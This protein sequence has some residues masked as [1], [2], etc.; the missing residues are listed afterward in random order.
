[1]LTGTA[2]AERCMA[3]HDEF[4][5]SREFQL[6]WVASGRSNVQYYQG[7]KFTSHEH[8][9][10]KGS[11]PRIGRVP[12]NIYHSFMKSISP[13]LYMVRPR[14][15]AQ[16]KD[17]RYH[18]GS[19]Q[20]EAYLNWNLEVTGWDKQIQYAIKNAL[21]YGAGWMRFGFGDQFGGIPSAMDTVKAGDARSLHDD[22]LVDGLSDGGSPGVD[23][24]QRERKES[25]KGDQHKQ[26]E[27]VADQK[28]PR[29]QQNRWILPNTVW[30]L[31]VN[32]EDI[33]LDYA[34]SS[35]DDAR[36]LIHVHYM[37]RRQFEKLVKEKRFDITD[38]SLVKSYTF[39][40]DETDAGNEVDSTRGPFWAQHVSNKKV[41]GNLDLEVVK[42]M[43]FWDREHATWYLLGDGL[44][45]KPLMQREWPGP[46]DQFP[47]VDL[48]FSK[49]QDL[50]YPVADFTHLAPFQ[51]QLNIF[52]SIYTDAVARMKTIIATQKGMIESGEEDAALRS[53]VLAFLKFRKPVDKMFQT[54][55]I[56][57]HVDE[58]LRAISVL[59]AQARVTFGLPQEEQGAASDVESATQASIIANKSELKHHF[60]KMVVDEFQARCHKMRAVMIRLTWP[61][62]NDAIY[63]E[64]GKRHPT[65]Q[66]LM[67][68]RSIMTGGTGIDEAGDLMTLTGVNHA[69]M[70]HDYRWDLDPVVQTPMEK[71]MLFDRVMQLFNVAMP[72]GA[73]NAWDFLE[74]IMELLEIRRPN[75]LEPRPE[76]RDA[77][78]EHEAML[79]GMTVQLQPGENHH[80]HFQKHKEMYDAAMQLRQQIGMGVE[81]DQ[82]KIPPLLILMASN[83]EALGALQ[84]HLKETEKAVTGGMSGPVDK[85]PD[86][87]S[88]RMS[89]A[90]RSASNQQASGVPNGLQGTF[91]GGQLSG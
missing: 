40:R 5:V 57:A 67:G 27:S 41:V 74:Y 47:Y 32:P 89:G 3:L 33:I 21:L 14:A 45:D 73:A 44:K 88:A 34:A 7:R 25:V 50:L 69:E 36:Y 84:E 26:T 39:K 2:L 29:M 30:G 12:I 38:A 49:D 53:G 61:I 22:I 37:N 80:R 62:M 83:D 48:A 54:V 72:T 63:N 55:H 13:A 76:T 6:P 59:E 15:L 77:G 90:K 9:D 18:Y 46:D 56:E 75:L 17:P 78:Q 82:Q 86:P 68:N 23:A 87:N 51:D 10:F 20:M 19:Q 43:E 8:E 81:L 1:M 64:S 66:E 91:Q 35:I 85:S 65:A 58:F 42:L 79:M 11:K 71:S 16:P 24:L 70:L 60:R 28:N 52:N 31:S 4:A